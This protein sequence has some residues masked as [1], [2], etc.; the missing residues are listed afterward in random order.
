MSYT[1]QFPTARQLE[2]LPT[3]IESHTC[4]LKS[5][6]GTVRLWLSRCDTLDGEPFTHTVYIEVLDEENWR[7]VDHGYYDGDNPIEDIAGFSGFYFTDVK[8]EADRLIAQQEDEAAIDWLTNKI[9]R[10]NA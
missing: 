6:D 9:A 5:D 4:D 2:A 1:R 10:G 8:A 3:R 7:W